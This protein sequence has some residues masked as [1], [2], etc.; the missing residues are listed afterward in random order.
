MESL[1]YMILYFLK[2]R[3]PWHGSKGESKQQTYQLIADRKAGMCLDELCSDVP[4]EF[5]KYMEYT[6]TLNF[7][8]KPDYSKL[9]HIFR[10]LF[11]RRGF[12]Y[13]YV[14]D[15]TIQKYIESLQQ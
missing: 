2:G 12:E 11:I 10:N 5:R 15:W 4:Q 9:R 6:R 7:G 3:L 14:F 1:G 8:D 13:D